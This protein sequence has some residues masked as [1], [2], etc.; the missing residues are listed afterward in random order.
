MK[1]STR[2]AALS[3]LLVRVPDATIRQL[4]VFDPKLA[5][6]PCFCHYRI[7]AIADQ[8]FFRP[9][10]KCLRSEDLSYMCGLGSREVFTGGAVLLEGGT[11]LER[12]AKMPRGGVTFTTA[13]CGIELWRRGERLRCT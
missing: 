11:L 3:S 1:A 8:G 2:A 13:G 10:L 4:D 6:H 5:V 12:K 7:I 9:K